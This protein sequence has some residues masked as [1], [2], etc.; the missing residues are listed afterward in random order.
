[1]FQQYIDNAD[2][3][4]STEDYLLVFRP[5]IQANQVVEIESYTTY[6]NN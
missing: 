2:C 5:A 3:Q 6:T 1:M 4:I